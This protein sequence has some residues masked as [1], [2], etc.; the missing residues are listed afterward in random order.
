MSAAATDEGGFTLVE[1]MIAGTLGLLLVLPGYALL[2][3]TYRFAD[4]IESRVHQSE[5][6]RQVLSLLGDGTSSAA[7]GT[8]ARGFGLIE[9]LRSRA[10]IPS[11]WT[12]R[13]SG[14]FIMTDGALQITGDAVPALNVQCTAAA[15]PVPDCKGT[16][17]RTINGWL[18]SDPVLS[19]AAGHVAAVGIAVTDPFRA[20]RVAKYPGMVT[21][22]FRTLFGLNVEANP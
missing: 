22:N 21:E 3:S 5:Q 6:A 8:D 11:P 1:A 19:S 20:Q 13:R 9:G 16:E 15:T 10:S 14:Q 12:L 18:G 2:A 17:A 4:L 7:T